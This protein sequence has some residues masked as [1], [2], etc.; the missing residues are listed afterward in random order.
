MGR[1]QVSTT[2]RLTQRR[3]SRRVWPRRYVMKNRMKT[4]IFAGIT[5]AAIGGLAGLILMD[6]SY[7]FFVLLGFT[8]TFSV[9]G[10]FASNEWRESIIDWFLNKISP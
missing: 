8:L 2:N 7:P 9:I 1:S 4:A 10:F 6:D 5:G 3:A